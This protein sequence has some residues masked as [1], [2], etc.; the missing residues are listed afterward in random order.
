MYS[1]KGFVTPLIIVIVAILALGGG[2]FY[3][4][5]KPIK[6]NYYVHPVATTTSTVISIST[7]TNNTVDWKT[8]TD[9]QYGFEFKY[10]PTFEILQVQTE[11][12]N[13]LVQIA[14]SPV[15][16][17]NSNTIWTLIINRDNCNTDNR[18]GR[19][20]LKNGDLSYNFTCQHD[21]V[22]VYDYSQFNKFITTL[23]FITLDPVACTMDAKMCPDGTYVGRSGPNCEFVCPNNE[24]LI[25]LISPNG[26]EQWSLDHEQVISWIYNTKTDRLDKND[27]IYV[28]FRTPEELV[29]WTNIKSTIDTGLVKI[30]PSKVVCESGDVRNL[31]AGGLFRV[32]IGAIKY[33]DGMGVADHSD[34]Y[35]TIK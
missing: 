2:V 6:L 13:D 32:Q 19:F 12:F 11:A 5:N 24:S 4:L 29:C 27:E 17:D 1:Q 23:K 35:F 8:Y 22:G 31:K 16:Y 14:I 7:S 34:D 33:R 3:Y 28:G 10:P 9:T 18:A 26:G 30:I 21:N 15:K 20:C 25:T